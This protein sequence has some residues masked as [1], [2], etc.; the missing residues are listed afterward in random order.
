MSA[1]GAAEQLARGYLEALMHGNR[2]AANAA[3]GRGPDGTDFPEAAFVN[4]RTRITD[5]HATPNGDGTYK[6]EIELVTP[7]NGTFFC[8]FQAAHNDVAAYLSD[9]YCIRVQ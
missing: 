2:G 4:A 8:T 5:T 3:L 6:V 9:H 1:S 7:G